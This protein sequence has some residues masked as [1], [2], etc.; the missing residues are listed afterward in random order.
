MTEGNTRGRGFIGRFLGSWELALGELVIVAL[1]VLIALWADQWMQDRQDTATAIGYLERLQV[2]VIADIKALSF[3]AD[4][5]RNRLAIT[6]QVDAWLQDPDA[7]PEPDELVMKVHFAGVLF[8]PTISKFT[9]EELRS[10]G[11]FRLLTNEALKR[12]VAD[13]YNQIG[14]QIEQWGTWGDEGITETYFRELAFVLEPESRLRMGTFDPAQMRQFLSTFYDEAPVTYSEVRGGGPK[15]GAT[16]A[17]A[18]RI[19]ARM[20][21]RPNFQG[22]LRDSMYWALLS[23]QLLDGIIISAEELEATIAAELEALS[24]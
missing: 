21:T 18:D 24:Q 2:D 7:E 20:R 4:Q 17:E 16:R 14:L 9:M 1:G 23:S 12:Q 11:D 22:Y 19:L 13:Y 15:I 5:A 3:S 8:P 6:Q 10:T